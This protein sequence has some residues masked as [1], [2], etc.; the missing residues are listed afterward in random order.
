MGDETPLPET[1]SRGDYAVALSKIQDAID[2]SRR[3]QKRLQWGA[4]VPGS[5]VVAYFIGTASFA[6]SPEPSITLAALFGGGVVLAWRRY[7]RLSLAVQS[8]EEGIK[9]LEAQS[10][11]RNNDS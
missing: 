3:A 6:T 7:R 10:P 9:R 11:E 4:L 5:A 8:H 1:T 2:S